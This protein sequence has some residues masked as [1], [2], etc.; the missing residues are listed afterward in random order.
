MAAVATIPKY[1]FKVFI[2]CGPK[3]PLKD[4]ARIIPPIKPNIPYPK[5]IA[6]PAKPSLLAMK[7][8]ERNIPR[9]L[10]RIALNKTKRNRRSLDIAGCFIR[11]K[12]S[13]STE[14]IQ[15]KLS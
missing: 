6:A 11:V 1:I 4:R 2:L 3:R 5:T 8:R 10:P 7:N 14:R 12:L 15:T 9:K 13:K